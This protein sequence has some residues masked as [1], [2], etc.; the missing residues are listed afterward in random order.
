MPSFPKC[1]PFTLAPDHICEWPKCRRFARKAQGSRSRRIH[2]KTVHSRELVRCP[3]RHGSRFAIGH[4]TAGSIGP[5]PEADK[6][7]ATVPVSVKIPP[8]KGSIAPLRA[9]A[10]GRARLAT[11]ETCHCDPRAVGILRSFS[12]RVIAPIVIA[13]FSPKQPQDREQAPG[14]IVGRRDQDRS[15]HLPGLANIRWIAELRYRSPS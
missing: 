8:I 11:L 6:L 1:A 4:L 3:P 12:D 15:A 10:H 9:S 5:V 14:V 13:A 2:Y 7:T